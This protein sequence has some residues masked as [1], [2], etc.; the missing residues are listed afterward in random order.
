MRSNQRVPDAMPFTLFIPDF[1]RRHEAAGRPR[2]P[3]LERMVA[4][5]NGKRAPS[6]E[7]F[8]A[9]LFG[10]ET[11]QLVAAPFMHLADS[12]RRDGRYRLCAEFVHLAADRD[13]LVLMPGSLLQAMP[14]EIAALTT[15]FNQLYAA[16]GWELELTPSGRAYLSCPKPLDVVTH[17]PD[18]AAGQAVLEFMPA[19]TDAPRLKQLMNESQMLFH[20]HP[21]NQAREDAGR[22]LINSLWFWGG[23]LLPEKTRP[24]SSMKIMGDLPLLRGLALWAGVQP[25]AAALP[26][27]GNEAILGLAAMDPETLDHDWIGPLST[28]L[29]SGKLSRL[30][31]YLGGYGLFDLHPGAMHRFWRRGRP[32][33]AIEP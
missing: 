19:G 21:V 31:L 15:A 20:T 2:L 32:L 28:Q 24:I 13:Q 27:D 8:L 12:G 23:G 25:E 9:P 30:A 14:E 5:G 6:P 29:K 10:L 26:A 22:P 4:R 11:R 33:T 3:V 18:G 16:E 1:R 17:A 7:E